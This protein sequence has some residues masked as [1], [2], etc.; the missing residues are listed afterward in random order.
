MSL[1]NLGLMAMDAGKS[2]IL[3]ASDSEGE[4][5]VPRKTR[6]HAALA[7][8]LV[9]RPC[10]CAKADCFKQFQGREEQ[11]VR[12]RQRFQSLPAFRK[13]TLVIICLGCLGWNLVQSVLT[14]DLCLKAIVLLSYFRDNSL[15][16]ILRCCRG[17]DD[18]R[19]VPS[20]TPG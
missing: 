20:P 2:D 13:D 4:F 17:A 6:D 16:L 11:V 15:A 14:M 19:L 3:A 18:Y 5:S 7:A 8:K 1:V 9:Q 12:E 10:T